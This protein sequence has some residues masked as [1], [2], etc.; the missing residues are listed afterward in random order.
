MLYSVGLVVEGGFMLYVKGWI[1]VLW[2][3]SEV[4]VLVSLMDFILKSRKCLVFSR[5]V[6]V[7]LCLGFIGGM[8]L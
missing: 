4:F 7:V 6:V 2:N 3:E 5:L 1:F 8:V